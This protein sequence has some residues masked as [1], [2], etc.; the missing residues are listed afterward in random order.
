MLL[1]DFTSPKMKRSLAVIHSE[2]FCPESGRASRHERILRT[3][4][5]S[6]VVECLD[7]FETFLFVFEN[8][9][10]NHKN[11]YQRPSRKN[12]LSKGS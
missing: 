5:G 1:V 9:F 11:T 12:D 3:E 6:R 7:C 4:S 2:Q 8:L 10:C